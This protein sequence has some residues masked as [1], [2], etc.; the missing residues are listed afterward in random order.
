MEVVQPAEEHP[1]MHASLANQVILK[2]Q[3]VIV[4]EIVMHNL[5]GLELQQILV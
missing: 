2:T 1:T 3:T 4:G 5:I